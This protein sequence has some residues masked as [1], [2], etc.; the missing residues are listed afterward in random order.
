MQ[1]EALVTVCCM[2][3]ASRYPCVHLDDPLP[4]MF[5]AN[6]TNASLDAGEQ[7]NLGACLL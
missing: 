6:A 3:A 7:T 4:A 2:T 5:K 1:H